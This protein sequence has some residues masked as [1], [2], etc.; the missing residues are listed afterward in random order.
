MRRHELT[1]EQFERIAQLLPGRK[2][3][4]GRNATDNRTFLNAVFWILKTDAPWRDLPL[5]Y[6]K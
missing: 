2:G 4:V 1:S 5:R 6:G 3:H